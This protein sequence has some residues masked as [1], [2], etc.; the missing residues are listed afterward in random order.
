MSTQ[1]Y[2][3]GQLLRKGRANQSSAARWD[4]SIDLGIDAESRPVFYALTLPE[5]LEAW[6]RPAGCHRVS[7]APQASGFRIQ[8]FSDDPALVT[9]DAESSICR[10]DQI[11]FNW[12]SG[13]ST[14][15][16]HIRLQSCAGRS[17]LHLR[18]RRFASEQESI[19]HGD[20]WTSSLERLAGFLEHRSTDGHAARAR[21]RAISALHRRRESQP[22][23]R[24]ESAPAWSNSAEAL[25]LTSP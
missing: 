14:S 23:Y 1:R 2:L 16:V 22:E 18:H 5:Y 24:H 4:F 11:V 19:W 17:I 9:V 15:I 21:I 10:P 12:S 20:L 8:F 7:V 3:V 25:L 13:S 6:L